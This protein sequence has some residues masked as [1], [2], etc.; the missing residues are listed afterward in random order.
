[1]LSPN[2]LVKYFLSFVSLFFM[3]QNL[4]IFKEKH[5]AKIFSGLM[6]GPLMIN[7]HLFMQWYFVPY[8]LEY[9]P[10]IWVLSIHWNDSDIIFLSW[11]ASYKFLKDSTS[12]IFWKRKETDKLSSQIALKVNLE[13][14]GIQLFL[15][16][17]TRLLEPH[18][19]CNAFLC[20]ESYEFH[21]R[22]V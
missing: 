16:V 17:E 2:W 18:I 9:F 3:I 12:N 15:H 8:L 4:Y 19:F 5:I 11:I 13:G 10:K 20:M 7:E 21:F 22:T 14:L 6:V 1:M